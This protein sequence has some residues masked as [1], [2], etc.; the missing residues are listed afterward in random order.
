[1]QTA[2]TDFVER[3]V[4][5]QTTYNQAVDIDD[6]AAGSV[7]WELYQRIE[8][9]RPVAPVLEAATLRALVRET[10]A[11]LILVALPKNDKE[12]KLLLYG[13]YQGQPDQIVIEERNEAQ[14]GDLARRM[15]AP[16][17]LTATWSGLVT[18][19]TAGNT[20]PYVLRVSPTAPSRTT[21]RAGDRIQSVEGKPVVRRRELEAAF[22]GRSPGD[23]VQVSVEREGAHEQAT[24]VVAETVVLPRP[25][26]TH[27]L[28][29]KVLL[30]IAH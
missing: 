12:A 9:N 5:Q 1:M 24:V 11:D 14:A 29:N 16:I 22:A 28:F 23:Q 30:H 25:G 26:D 3:V 10:D 27:I 8:A 15:S 20:F 6:D 18:V 17:E 19:E 7:R 13:S 21:V 2:R 4:K